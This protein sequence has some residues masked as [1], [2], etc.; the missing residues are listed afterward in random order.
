[1]NRFIPIVWLTVFACFF[2]TYGLA[3]SQ[4]MEVIRVVDNK[5]VGNL[6]S[7]KGI[8]RDQ[9]YI[10]YRIMST[11]PISIGFATVIEVKSS[12]SVLSVVQSE[13]DLTVST[14]DIL[15]RNSDHNPE[16]DTENAKNRTPHQEKT[17]TPYKGRIGIR[18]GVGIDTEGGL[19]GCGSLS[20]LVPTYPN[21][22]EIGFLVLSGSI[23]EE[24][25]NSHTY[26]V[27]TDI[28]ATS[29]YLNYLYNFRYSPTGLFLVLGTGIA[30][31]DIM[32][33]KSS[34]TDMSLG[35]PLPDGGS[36]QSDEGGRIGILF[37]FGLGYKFS[38]SVNLR[39]E[40]P[41]FYINDPPGEASSIATTFVFS[42]GVRFK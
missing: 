8:A 37:Q 15:I 5:I 7:E 24:T 42:F 21:P 32:W 3:F 38:N 16:L 19:V 13:S 28:L 17:S 25:E 12:L 35:K 36:T 1:M 40:V 27:R 10:I 23:E 26:L 9:Q 11:G 6:G 39:L 14:G 31:I 29:L 4:K 34:D 20:Y 2:C 18:G 30:F 22:F 41:V 33:E